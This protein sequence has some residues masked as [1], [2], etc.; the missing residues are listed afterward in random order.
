MRNLIS[1]LFC[2]APVEKE[3]SKRCNFIQTLAHFDLCSM[4]IFSPSPD[5]FGPVFIDLCPSGFP[6]ALQKIVSEVMV[7]WKMM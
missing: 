7:R 1:V 6:G 5:F 3:K 2:L 4:S